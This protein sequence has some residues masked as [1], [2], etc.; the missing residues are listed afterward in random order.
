MLSLIAMPAILFGNHP[1]YQ[2]IPT[3]TAL[4]FGLF[5]T[6]SRNIWSIAICYVIFACAHNN[7]GPI[8]HFLSLPMWKPLARL[9]YCIYLVHNLI[10]AIS[11]GSRHRPAY[12][13][14]ISAFR[15]F[16]SIYVISVFVSIPLVLAFELPIDAIVKL[17]TPSNFKND[18]RMCSIST[19]KGTKNQI[20]IVKN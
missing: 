7:G 12:F 19:D 4:E 2:V 20:C 13:S 15:N 11:N 17:S 1:Y 16:I 6:L 5:E 8:N 14:G 3:S 10:I 9:S 18:Q